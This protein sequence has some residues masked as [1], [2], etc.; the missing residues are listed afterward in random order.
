MILQVAIQQMMIMKVALDYDGVI[1]ANWSHYFQLAADL[2]KSGH[3]VHILTGAKKDRADSINRRLLSMDFSFHQIHKRPENFIST[4]KNIG[5]W[6][7]QILKQY[8]IDLWFDN[9]VKIYEQAG[10]SFNDLDLA[11]VRI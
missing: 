5:E 6:K 10:V 4:P 8:N 3:I 9:E 2:Y 7:K 11:I 1:S